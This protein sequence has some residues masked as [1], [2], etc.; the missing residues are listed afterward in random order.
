MALALRVLVQRQLRFQPGS[1]RDLRLA[2]PE[3]DWFQQQA[4]S[5]PPVPVTRPQQREMSMQQAN[6]PALEEASPQA[7]VK[8]RAALWPVKL[9]GQASLRGSRSAQAKRRG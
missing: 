2:W 6:S 5:S 9:P 1:R 8:V 3:L 4:D 7:R